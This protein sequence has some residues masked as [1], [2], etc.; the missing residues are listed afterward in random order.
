MTSEIAMA[1]HVSSTPSHRGCHRGQLSAVILLA[2]LA[3]AGGASRAAFAQP[4]GSDYVLGPRDVLAI[5]V[6]DQLDLSGKFTVE[7]DGTFAF[8]LAGKIQAGGR[9]ARQVEADMKERLRTEGIFTNPQITVVVET[10]A[11]QRVF[12]VGEVRTAGSYP[13]RGETTLLEALAEAGSPT[14]EAASEVLIVRSTGARDITKPVLPSDANDG[15]IM[16]VD[17]ALLQRGD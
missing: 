4:A 14:A 16:R 17:L 12:I 10:Y 11:S 9:S 7:P 6:W 13:L 3:V 2:A 15:D 5:T 1:R 8:P